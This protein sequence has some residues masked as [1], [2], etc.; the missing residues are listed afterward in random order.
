MLG[1]P[2]DGYRTLFAASFA[3]F[4]VAVDPL[5]HRRV[6]ARRAVSP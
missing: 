2:V 3:L 5:L 1:E 4:V 6:R